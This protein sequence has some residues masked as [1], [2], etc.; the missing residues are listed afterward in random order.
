MK[1]LFV[2]LSIFVALSIVG[3]ALASPARQV[4]FPQTGILDDFN[5]IDEGPPPSVNWTTPAGEIGRIVVGYQMAQDFAGGIGGIRG[6]VWNSTV[7]TDCEVYVTIANSGGDGSGEAIWA[8]TDIGMATGY[9]LRFIRDDTGGDYLSL[10]AVEIGNVTNVNH[11]L[12]N[13]D[14][15]GLRVIGNSIEILYKPFGGSWTPLWTGTDSSYPN[16]G[17][18]GVDGSGWFEDLRLDDFGG[19][20]AVAIKPTPTPTTIPS[21]VISS[22]IPYVIVPIPGGQAQPAI[23]VIYSLT[24]G[25]I[26]LAAV[27]LLLVLVIAGRW[28]YDVAMDVFQVRNAAI[29]SWVSKKLYK[30]WINRMVE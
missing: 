25:E 20:E 4:T 30:R 16:A 27:M 15:F 11:E 2:V 21:G 12:I 7:Y 8:R 23:Y 6:A 19:G 3:L 26:I 29:G 24:I 10:E 28:L 1:R 17:Y 22:T 18:I 13:G 9:S 5:R 14:S